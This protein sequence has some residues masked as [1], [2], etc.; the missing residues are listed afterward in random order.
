MESELKEYQL[1]LE[2][3]EAVLKGSPDNKELLDLKKEL[4]ELIS[5]TEIVIAEQNPAPA[6]PAPQ[7]AS[8]PP[9]TFTRKRPAEAAAE[10]ANNSVAQPTVTYNVGDQVQARWVS[11]DGALYPARITTVTGSSKNPVYVVTFTGYDNSTETLAAKDI[12]PGSNKKARVS[13]PA[14][15]AAPTNAAI[16]SQAPTLNP[17]ALE[18]GKQEADGDGTGK[19]AARKVRANKELDASKSKWQAFAAKGVKSNKA[20]KTKKIGEGSM[21]RTPDGIHGRVG[22]TGSGQPMRKDAAREKHVYQRTE[23]DD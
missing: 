12:R 23:N 8:A 20:G 19:K 10:T 17:G 16:I 11:G 13:P 1:Q 4:E 5:L 7:S 15:P 22:F 6:S 3:V 18:A 2:S 14:Q 9:T 21:F